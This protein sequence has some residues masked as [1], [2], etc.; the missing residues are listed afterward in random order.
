[1]LSSPRLLRTYVTTQTVFHLA[2]MSFFHFL[3]CFL[4]L[5]LPCAH[6]AVRVCAGPRLLT[7]MGLPLKTIARSQALSPPFHGGETL[8]EIFLQTTETEHAEA[9][10][11]AASA[12][13]V[14]NMEPERQGELFRL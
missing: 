14:V 8:S 3:V 5:A 12:D 4:L 9:E 13:L 6:V 10:A 1:M 7:D 11:A 2:L